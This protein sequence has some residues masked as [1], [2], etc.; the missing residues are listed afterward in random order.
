MPSA[1]ISAAWIT[2]SGSIINITRC[3]SPFSLA[4]LLSCILC[5][6]VL[7]SEFDRLVESFRI[8]LTIPLALKVVLL[9]LWDT[10]PPVRVTAM[11]GL[12]L[13]TGIVVDTG[14][15]MLHYIRLFQ[16]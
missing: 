4:C 13:L 16:G 11:L 10:S 8:I 3:A 7:S 15:I 9:M 1:L 12:V 14:I 6:M 2:P 5:Y